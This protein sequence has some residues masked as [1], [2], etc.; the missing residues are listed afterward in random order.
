M[1]LF[2]FN[3]FGTQKA[4]EQ[5]P[6]TQQREFHIPEKVFIGPYYEWSEQEPASLKLGVYNLL[7]GFYSSQNFIELFYSVP[8]VFAPVHEIASRVADATWQLKKD[9]NDEVDYKDADFNRL[10]TQPNPL[11]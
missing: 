9:W 5:T 10:F 2:G 1:K 4:Y 6:V 7:N 3:L 11:V 8:E